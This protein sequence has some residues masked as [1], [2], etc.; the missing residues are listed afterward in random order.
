MKFGVADYGMNVWAGGSYD[1]EARL[2]DLRAIG[3]NGTERLECIDAADAMY[4]AAAYRRMGMD[5]ATCRGPN[6][7]IAAEAAGMGDPLRHGNV[8]VR[9]ENQFFV[10][11]HLPIIKTSIFLLFLSIILVKNYDIL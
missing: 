10:I 2:E 11:F 3:Y 9:V 8:A 5:F 7:E 6:P 1:F 4:K